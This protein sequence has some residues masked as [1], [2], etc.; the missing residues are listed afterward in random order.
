MKSPVVSGGKIIKALSKAGFEIVGRRGSHIRMRKI[1]DKDKAVVITVPNH[2][3]L[4]L[5]TFN[6]IIKQS[7]LTKEEFLKLL[8]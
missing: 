8:K 3:E 4:A 2:R 5:G 1:I 6:D 7:G